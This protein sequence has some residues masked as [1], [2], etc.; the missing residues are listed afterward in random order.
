MAWTN[1]WVEGLKPPLDAWIKA[2]KVSDSDGVDVLP[3]EILCR[4]PIMPQEQTG[5]DDDGNPVYGPK[6]GV[7]RGIWLFSFEGDAEALIAEIRVLNGPYEVYENATVEN[8][9]D[10]YPEYTLGQAIPYIT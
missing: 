9:R 8:M 2:K 1:I 4:G 3:H 10:L 5:T 7:Q 6:G